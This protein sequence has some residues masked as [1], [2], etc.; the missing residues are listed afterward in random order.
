MKRRPKPQRK[1][2]PGHI[3]VTPDMDL[4]VYGVQP[5]R[6]RVR[7]R[8]AWVYL[9]GAHGERVWGCNETWWRFNVMGERGR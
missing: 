5:G 9:Y 7:V 3:T 4:G 1:A 2:V 6:Y 8:N